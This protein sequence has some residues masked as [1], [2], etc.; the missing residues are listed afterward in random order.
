MRKLISNL[1][2]LISCLIL[3]G[4]SSSLPMREFPKES[5]LDPIPYNVRPTKTRNGNYQ[6]IINYSNKE[7]EVEK[8]A[9]I[10]MK[11]DPKK[12]FDYFENLIKQK[13]I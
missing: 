11:R 5:G 1:A 6:W 2:V 4:C 3:Y 13:T 8:K 7:G 10:L 12:Y 9:I